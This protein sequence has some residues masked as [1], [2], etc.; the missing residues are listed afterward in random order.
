MK[1][2]LLRDWDS[3]HS[4]AAAGDTVKRAMELE[5]GVRAC[6]RN[7]ACGARKKCIKN[8]YK[9]VI[10][11]NL[12]LLVPTSNVPFLFFPVQDINISI[13]FSRISF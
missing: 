13:K 9:D 8:E 4:I 1:K 2:C 10:Q 3:C 6:R 5:F 12:Y 11:E 7:F